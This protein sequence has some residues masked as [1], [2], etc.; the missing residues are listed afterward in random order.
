MKKCYYRTNAKKLGAK[1]YFTGVPCKK[2]HIS[3]RYTNNADCVECRR[4]YH[5]KY[6]AKLRSDLKYRES[7]N[8]RNREWSKKNKEYVLLRDRTYRSN[9]REKFN[10]YASKRRASILNATPNWL[11]KEHLDEIEAKYELAIYLEN[12]LGRKYHVDHIIPLKA[13]NICGLHVPWN[14]QVIDASKNISK[15]NRLTSKELEALTCIA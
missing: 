15:G 14:L 10:S 5:K 7:E 8:R 6:Q 3:D 9:N 4:D 12:K 13:E 1:T 11:T 2:G